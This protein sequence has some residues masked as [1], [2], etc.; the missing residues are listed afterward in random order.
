[1]GIV[2]LKLGAYC[3]FYVFANF[4]LV[5]ATN[6]Y[7]TTPVFKVVLYKQ[8]PTVVPDTLSPV[9]NAQSLSIRTGHLPVFPRKPSPKSNWIMNEIPT[10]FNFPN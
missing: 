7:T 1:M 10:S 6:P 5:I 2:L 9:S 4:P 3:S 8:R